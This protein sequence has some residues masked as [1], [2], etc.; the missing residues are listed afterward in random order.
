MVEKELLS[1]CLLK[2]NTITIPDLR[3]I[4]KIRLLTIQ[5]LKVWPRAKAKENLFSQL[6][7]RI[8]K[9]CLQWAN[10]IIKTSFRKTLT[11]LR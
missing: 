1:V 7:K 11:T 2:Q 10:T 3:L 8:P 9:R 4:K 5:M 6:K